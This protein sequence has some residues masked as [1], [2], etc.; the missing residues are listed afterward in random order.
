MR[1]MRGHGISNRRYRGGLG[2][3]A[4]VR[5]CSRR[6]TADR[7]VHCYCSPTLCRDS[8][9]VLQE[10]QS[11][12]RSFAKPE[13]R[14]T[15]IPSASSFTAAHTGRYRFSF[16]G[17]TR[18]IFLWLALMGTE[19]SLGRPSIAEKDSTTWHASVCTLAV[20]YQPAD[21]RGRERRLSVQD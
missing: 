17:E 9:E 3:N 18:A 12:S 4:A 21:F 14:N 2:R 11:V 13:E 6:R 10:L 20:P 19:R 1:G 7:E 5:L 8:V 16:R 15:R